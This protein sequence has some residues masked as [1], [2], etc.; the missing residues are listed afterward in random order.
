MIWKAQR[1]DNL[2]GFKYWPSKLILLFK[3]EKK[4]RFENFTESF[5]DGECF[6][7]MLAR[8]IKVSG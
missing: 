6:H 4:L 3:R 5:L 2:K 1:T 7:R 8:I